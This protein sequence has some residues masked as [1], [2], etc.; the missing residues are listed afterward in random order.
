MTGYIIL[1]LH[2]PVQS[3]RVISHEP[4]A[5]VM[6]AVAG[7]LDPGHRQI[8]VCAPAAQLVNA[9]LA[10]HLGRRAKSQDAAVGLPYF[11]FHAIAVCQYHEMVHIKA[12]NEIPWKD[13]FQA[14]SDLTQK[15]V[16]LRYAV[17]HIEKLEMDNVKK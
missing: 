4:V 12:G 14:V 8:R 17:G 6:D 10:V 7:N 9:C 1:Q 5:A 16:P 13:L 15:S 2:L 3:R 11:I